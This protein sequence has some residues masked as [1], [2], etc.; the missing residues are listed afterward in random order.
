MGADVAL[1]PEMWNIAY[2]PYDGT[3]GDYERTGVETRE[4]A[5]ARRQWQALAI[6][7]EGPFVEHFRGLART[8]G[9]AVAITYLQR[10]PG[11]PRNTVTLFD[12]HREP[13][14]T[15]AKVHTCDFDLEDA[16]T[17]GDDF[18]VAGLDTAAGPVRV[19]AM[20]CYD[21]EFP[22][23][24]RIIMLKGAEI[25][26]VPNACTMERYRLHALETR[27]FE[28]MVGVAM[29]N[30]GGGG[31]EKN[32]HSAAYDGMVYDANG[33]WRDMTLGQCLP[34]ASPVR[35]ANLYRY[36]AAVRPA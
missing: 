14:L 18:C 20:I 22:E 36:G 27:A 2:T 24:A 1:F 28:N 7:S 10:W 32:G 30:Y 5:E 8:L 17:P 34:P 35:P 21:R 16:C 19:G 23:S 33:V 26:L 3:P 13:A 9:V 31:P 6:E 15:Y 4:Q 25:V 12:R 29:A 11:A